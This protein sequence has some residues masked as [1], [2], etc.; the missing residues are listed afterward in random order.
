MESSHKVIKKI[1][2]VINYQSGFVVRKIRHS[3][4]ASA[5]TLSKLKERDL[6]T[7]PRSLVNYEIYCF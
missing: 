3:L 2:R 5:W 1:V 7:L 4:K 6:T